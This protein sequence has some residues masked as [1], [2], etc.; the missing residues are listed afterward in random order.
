MGLR[1]RGLSGLGVWMAELPVSVLS[2]SGAMLVA[3]IGK[4]NR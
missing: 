1:F 3:I 4:L 2:N